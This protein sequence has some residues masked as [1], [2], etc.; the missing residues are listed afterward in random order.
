MMTT[1]SLLIPIVSATLG[2]LAAGL[3]RTLLDWLDRSR[4]R[5][6][7]L[8]AFAGEVGILCWIVRH[9]YHP[10]RWRLIADR[11]EG[12]ETTRLALDLSENYFVVYENLSREIGHL[13]ADGAAIIIE[14]YTICKIAIDTVGMQSV[15]STNP[16]N[17]RFAANLIEVGLQLGDRIARLPR[18]GRSA[19]PLGPPHDW[20]S[21]YTGA[22]TSEESADRGMNRAV[23]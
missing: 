8:K 18:D 2:A 12:G 9:Q 11:I 4:N 15:Y 13:R 23:Q 14:F 7:I 17:M 3:L 19:L 1:N 16:Q 22:L 10:D 21:T 6:S 20:T 5:Q